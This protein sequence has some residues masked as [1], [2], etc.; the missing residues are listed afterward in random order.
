MKINRIQIDNFLGARTIDARLHTPIT[1]FCGHNFAGKSS[2]QEAVRMAI[3]GDVVRVDLKK[4]Y[5]QLVTDGAKAGGALLTAEAGAYAFE[6]PGG[7]VTADEGLPV[8]PSIGVALVGQR[9]ASM[10]ADDKRTFLFNLTGC[11]AS[12]EEVKKRLL[13]AHCEAALVEAVLPMLR[14]G[15][16]AACEYAKEQALQSK[17]DWKAVTGG[18]YGEKVAERWSCDMP[19]KPE[20]TATVE[21]LNALDTKIADLHQEIGA[22]AAAIRMVNDAA[23]KRLQLKAKADSADDKQELLELKR[24]E[25]AEYEPKVI[26]MRM[27]AAGTARVGLLHSLAYAIEGLINEAQDIKTM[28]YKNAV[29]VLAEYEMEHGPLPLEGTADVDAKAAL[30]EYE[31]GLEVLQNAVKNLERDLQDALAARAALAESEAI[32]TDET[33]DSLQHR[34]QVLTGLKDQR[35]QIAATLRAM[36]AYEGTVKSCREA[37][38]RAA[39][40]HAKVQE[41]LKIAVQLSPDGIPGQLLAEALQPLNS[42][43][44]IAAADTKW[45][46]VCI[47]PDME[48]IAGKRHYALLSES[49]K[50]RV[51]A[52]IAQA[53]AKISGHKILMLDRV[54]V[55]D[56]PSRGALLGWLDMLAEE[57]TIETALLF[58]TLKGVPSGLPATIT[59]YWIENGVLAAEAQKVAA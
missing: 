25:L 44:Q 4:E 27:R 37:T 6:V 50:W 14:S 10:S 19:S 2:I 9:F 12:A 21:E 53:V 42:T 47:T 30:P 17:R 36:E 56:I 33:S 24:A 59:A 45:P 29:A 52:M 34:Q 43:L 13:A 22:A 16:P 58:A 35:E 20:S 46:C 54:D 40:H 7:K 41:W 49:E 55:L 23:A 26:E 1:L 38:E 31:R 48:I 18:T 39:A 57:G 8:G 51:D 15:F 32:T 11:R 3:T 5:G 28:A